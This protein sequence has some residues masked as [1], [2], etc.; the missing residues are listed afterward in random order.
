MCYLEAQL[1]FLSI[2]FYD[3]RHNLAII[4]LRDAGGQALLPQDWG[5]TAA[6]F[7]RDQWVCLGFLSR[8]SGPGRTSPL[9]DQTLRAALGCSVDALTLLP[10][11]MVLPALTFMSTALAQ[12]SLRSTVAH[13][14]TLQSRVYT[15]ILSGV[16]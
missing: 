12:V 16:M 9:S 6:H 15:F 1:D 5:R 7:I 3:C 8:H 10:S 2:Y 11:G 14:K 13:K 4:C